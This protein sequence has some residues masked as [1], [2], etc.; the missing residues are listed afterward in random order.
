MPP[1]RR[2][3]TSSGP[4]AKGAQKT[5]SFGNKVTKPTTAVPYG[6]DIS[7]PKAHLLKNSIKQEAEAEPE[8]K[9]ELVAEEVKA[10]LDTGHVDSSAAVSQQAKAEIV[11]QAQGDGKSEDVIKAEKVTDAQVKKYWRER[12]GERRTKRVH[13]EELG[14][15]EKILRLFDMSSQYGVSFTFS[16]VSPSCIF[17]SFPFKVHSKEHDLLSSCSWGSIADNWMF[18]A[19]HRH[20]THETLD[21]STETGTCAS[22]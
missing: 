11:A 15:E 17:A 22:D 14:V 8:P 9:K 3:R 12:E 2:S 20:C 10:E 16:S 7:S 19:C 13:Q 1:A 5:L 4:A 18:V 21:S 6:K